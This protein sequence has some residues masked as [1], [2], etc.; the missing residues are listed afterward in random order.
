[1]LSS[2]LPHNPNED[3]EVPEVSADGISSIDFSPTANHMAATAW[4]CTV[5]IWEVS[6]GPN[7]GIQIAPKAMQSHN[8]PLLCSAFH[9]DGSGVYFGGTNG[10]VKLWDFG[11]NQV[12]QVA[13]HDGGVREC[14]FLKDHGFLVTGSWD[15]KVCYW[16]CRSS[17]PVHTQPVNER[18]YAMDVK[19]NMLTVATANRLLEVFDL[20]NPAA[21][22]MTMESPLKWQTRCVACFHDERGFLVGSI[23][24]RVGVHHC[25]SNLASNNFTFKCHRQTESGSKQEV[26]A[27]NAIKVHPTYGT[28]VTCGSDGSFH[29]WDKEVKRRLKAME[30]C[31]ESISC[32]S[33]NADASLFAYAVSYDWRFGVEQYNPD[34]KRSHIL[35]HLV[36]QSDVQPYTASK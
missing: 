34:A 26:Y 5:R 19:G 23:E 20:R 3:H 27:V 35:V 6:M 28:F 14:F 8:E 29:F 22:R 9:H 15:K 7:G 1:M 18:V 24:G 2:P 13:Q 31:N 16:D 17:T 11:S 4:D 36:N 33:F 12:R 25:D 10:Q 30:R 32:A 21:P